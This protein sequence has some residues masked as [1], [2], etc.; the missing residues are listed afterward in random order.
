M[1]PLQLIH[2]AV[3]DVQ[4]YLHINILMVL[5]D[6]QN[7]VKSGISAIQFASVVK[8]SGGKS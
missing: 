5:T 6:M 1:K 2:N 8:I 4:M 7:L 3:K